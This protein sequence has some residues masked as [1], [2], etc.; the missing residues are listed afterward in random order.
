LEVLIHLSSQYERSSFHHSDLG[1]SDTK[2]NIPHK[3]EQYVKK[4]N[5]LLTVDHVK[6]EQKEKSI[7][8]DIKT[9]ENIIEKVNKQLDGTTSTFHFVFEKHSL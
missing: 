2:Q 6:H 8:L 1:L 9:N 7:Q 3:D 5:E 4:E